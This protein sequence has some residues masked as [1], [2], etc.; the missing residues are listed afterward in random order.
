MSSAICFNFNQAKLKPFADNELNVAQMI[1][2]I[3][4]RVEKTLWEKEK[5]LVT[6]IFCFSHNVTK[7]IFPQGL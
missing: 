4:N 3:I 2:S 6:S 7:H 1:I 5:L